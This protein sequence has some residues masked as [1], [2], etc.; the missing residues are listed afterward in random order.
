MK[1]QV[2]EL[3][4]V[5][6]KIVV[7]LPS[8]IVDKELG[9]QYKR[10]GKTAR[11][12]GFRPGKVPKQLVRKMFRADAEQA[13][14]GQLVRSNI[15][16]AFDEASVEPLNVPDIDRDPI[17][18]GEAFTFS[19]VCQVRPEIEL[20]GI[21][22]ITVERGSTAMETTGRGKVMEPRRIGWPGSQRVSPVTV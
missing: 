17:V 8:D 12:R 20:I 18:E 10:L 15:T 6:R 19:L 3:S 7:E 2:E 14:G 21:D 13:A 22:D 11:V 9:A 1:V 5:E 4:A 16:Q